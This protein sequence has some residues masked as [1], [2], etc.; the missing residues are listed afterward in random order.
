MMYTLIYSNSTLSMSQEIPYS[1]NVS[2][3]EVA[4]LNEFTS[5][6]FTVDAST[7]VGAGP[8]AVFNIT[9]AGAGTYSVMILH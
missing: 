5:Y 4:G 9:T 6:S 2:D 3:F 8:T 7:S 1:E